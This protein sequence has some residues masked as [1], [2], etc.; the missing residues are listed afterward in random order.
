MKD[1]LF[2][3]YCWCMDCIERIDWAAAMLGLSIL[4][5]IVYFVL[6]AVTA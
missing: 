4:L 1:F 5:A 3:L 2:E 6:L